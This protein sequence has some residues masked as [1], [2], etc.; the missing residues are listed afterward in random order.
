M[1][2]LTLCFIVILLSI[3]TSIL[4][5]KPVINLKHLRILSAKYFAH[6]FY[7]NEL[8][9]ILLIDFG[10]LADR[11]QTVKITK[12]GEFVKEEDVS[13]LPEDSIYELDLNLL[14]KGKYTVE[15]II[16]TQQ[17]ITNELKIN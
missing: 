9:N 17:S 4:N 16:N 7:L 6:I 12:N 5:S 11:V 14:S 2:M 8:G 13:E 10:I 15:L 3:F 1:K